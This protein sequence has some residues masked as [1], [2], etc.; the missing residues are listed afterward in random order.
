[1]EK[2]LAHATAQ[3]GKFDGSTL[4]KRFS[5]FSNK[6]DAQ[7]E[8]FIQKGGRNFFLFKFQLFWVRIC[9]L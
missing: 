1:M 9:F 4:M 3:A 6:I 8:H 2:I 5:K 7:W